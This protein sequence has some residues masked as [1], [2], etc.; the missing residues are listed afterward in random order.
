MIL[1]NQIPNQTKLNI[2]KVNEG[3]VYVEFTVKAVINANSIQDLY[4]ILDSDFIEVEPAD[5]DTSEAAEQIDIDG[6]LWRAK[7][8]RL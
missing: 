4:G 2:E 3:Q 1:M 7:H 8:D 5:E 6:A